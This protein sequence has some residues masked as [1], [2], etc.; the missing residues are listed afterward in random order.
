MLEAWFA[1]MTFGLR[2]YVNENSLRM[3]DELSYV[4]DGKP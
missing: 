2:D 3:A 1:F 4:A